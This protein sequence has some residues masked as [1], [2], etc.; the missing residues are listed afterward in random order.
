MMEGR[1][2]VKWVGCWG[3]GIPAASAGMTE[4]FCAGVTE[5]FRAGMTEIFCAGVAELV[6]RGGQG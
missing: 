6:L 2:G 5:L 3:G 4:I 1:R